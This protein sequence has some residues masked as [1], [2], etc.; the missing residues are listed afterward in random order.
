[1]LRFITFVLRSGAGGTVP[2]AI[3]QARG[4]DVLCSV[5]NRGSGAG[6]RHRQRGATPPRCKLLN[7]ADVPTSVRV[8]MQAGEW[9]VPE[10]ERPF[11]KEK[12]R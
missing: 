2:E 12:P 11:D 6:V 4:G 8:L 3:R 7:H 1:M 9:L 10:S 5:N